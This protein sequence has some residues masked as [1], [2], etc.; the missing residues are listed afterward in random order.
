MVEANI[1]LP[2]P[3]TRTLPLYLI[4]T[5]RALHAGALSVQ[6]ESEQ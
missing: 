1:F 4:A 3:L 5:Q 6:L 2:L